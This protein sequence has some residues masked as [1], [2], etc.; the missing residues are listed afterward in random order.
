MDNEVKEILISIS[1]TLNDLV[2]EAKAYD[3]I[4]P[5]QNSDGRAAISSLQE[6]GEMAL[7]E[8]S[9]V[10]NILDSP[11]TVGPLSN[12]EKEVLNLVSKGMSNKEVA[13]SLKIEAVTYGLKM[14]W[15]KI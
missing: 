14:G 13:Y 8:V 6:L 1:K 9:E 2:S 15:I 11:L 3:R 4:L 10:Q 7:K 12:R 5:P